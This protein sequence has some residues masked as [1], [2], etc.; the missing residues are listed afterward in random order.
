M[1]WAAGSHPL[2]AFGSGG[3]SVYKNDL[4]GRTTMDNYMVICESVAAF[5]D[6]ARVSTMTALPGRKAIY[7]RR[8]VKWTEL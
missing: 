7:E 4:L 5:I 6:N 1:V 3:V 8:V 2:R